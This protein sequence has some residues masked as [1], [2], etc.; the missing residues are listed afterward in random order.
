[1]MNPSARRFSPKWLFF[2]SLSVSVICRPPS[3]HTGDKDAAKAEFI[4]ATEAF[5]QEDYEAALAG[6]EASYRIFPKA[7]VLYNI[8]MCEKA[9]F[10]DVDALSTFEKYVEDM[11]DGMTPEKQD[12]VNREIAEL[13][14][15]VGTIRILDTPD[16]AEIF[17][18]ETPVGRGPE[19]MI[20]RVKPGQHR[21]VVKKAGYDAFDSV[22]MVKSN[23]TYSLRA[24]LHPSKGTLSV[25]CEGSSEAAARVAIDGNDMGG[26]PF[27]G[28]LTPGLHQVVV[29]AEGM[30]GVNRRVAVA[31]SARST[32]V[33]HLAPS[34]R[35]APNPSVDTLPAR[36][37]DI[38]PGLA[39]RHPALKVVGIVSI[40]AGATTAGGLGGTFTYLS[41]E[42]DKAGTR[43]ARRMT[44]DADNYDAH[45]EDRL[46]AEDDLGRHRPMMIV[47]YALGG[48]LL[49]AGIVLTV[50][51]ANK[52]PAEK[53]DVSLTGGG[54]S[55]RF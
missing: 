7:S 17:L 24:A 54:L 39:R 3:A 52:A 11:G 32:I 45:N 51:G 5:K 31:S 41:A 23:D 33:V 50:I 2:L 4:A 27:E 20:V 13:R 25:N 35:S 30:I 44:N 12:R 8:G 48:T 43:A 53:R 1:M 9:L 49:A 46:N 55:V 10:R 21:V 29:T 37:V 42:D 38:P 36:P 19:T 40:A 34:K 26:C 14:T 18:N 22:F 16:E 6:F 15:K 47:G 28:P